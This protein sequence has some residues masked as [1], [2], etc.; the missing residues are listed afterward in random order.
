MNGVK[1]FFELL[2]TIQVFLVLY[3][4]I[5]IF[6]VV[7][8]PGRWSNSCQNVAQN[9]CIYSTFSFL[10]VY[11]KTK[12]KPNSSSV[13]IQTNTHISTILSPSYIGYIEVPATENEPP[14]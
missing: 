7:D 11:Q 14:H 1:Y 4:Y 8:R 9:I 2:S 5:F 10:Q 3:F 13:V 6:C 12:P